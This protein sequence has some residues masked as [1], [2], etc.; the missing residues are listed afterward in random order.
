MSKAKRKENKTAEVKNANKE[1][2]VWT[3]DE[4]ELRGPLRFLF[5]PLNS[6]VRTRKN[7]QP[8]DIERSSNILFLKI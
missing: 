8:C 2:F 7:Q 4:I 5:K 1:A 3:D 6:C